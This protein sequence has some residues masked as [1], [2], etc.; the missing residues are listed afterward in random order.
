MR[1]TTGAGDTF[2][3]A[4]IAALAEAQAP[5]AALRLACAVAGAKVAQEGFEGLAAPYGAARAKLVK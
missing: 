5:Q 4:C 2:I 3:G 1:D